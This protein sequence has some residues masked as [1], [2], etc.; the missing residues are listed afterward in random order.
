MRRRPIWTAFET[1]VRESWVWRE[2]HARHE[3]S[4]RPRRSSACFWAVPSSGSIRTCSAAGCP[5]PCTAASRITR[6]CSLPLSA[7]QISYPKPDGRISFDRLSSVFLS[8]TNH[9]ED[10]PCHL[11]LAGSGGAD[12]RAICRS[13]P[14]RRS[15]TVRPASTKSWQQPDGQSAPA[16]QCAEL[17]PLQDLRH[18]GS[19]AEHPLGDAGRR[20]RAEL[21]RDVAARAGAPTSSS[22]AVAM[23][24]PPP[25]QAAAMPRF[26]PRVFS[27][28][29]SV[30]MMRAPVA[31]IG[32]PSAQAP[33][34]TFTRSCA[35][36]RSRMAASVDAGKGLVDL[37]QVDIGDL[38]VARGQQLS[39]RP[40][41]VRW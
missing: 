36:P 27:A 32:W 15:G 2:L 33:P 19:G 14:S 37:E 4:A 23:A 21:L 17:R 41:P 34:C 31:P 1:A 28:L 5:S 18:Q 30:T 8:S 40:D 25:M 7:P 6:A 26:P 20:R 11:Q 10:Q 16:D 12:R 9:E 29:I 24:S 39:S 3:I 22:I 38:P 13:M 35:M